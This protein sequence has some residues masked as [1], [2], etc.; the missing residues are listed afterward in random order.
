MSKA[1]NDSPLVG[2]NF[3]AW[4]GFG[5]PSKPKSIWEKDD[6]FIG[7]PPYEFQGW[8]SVYS[9]DLSTIKIIKIFSSKFNDI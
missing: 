4:D 5:R 6:E 3:W 1:K 9:S 7:N 2:S 8:Y